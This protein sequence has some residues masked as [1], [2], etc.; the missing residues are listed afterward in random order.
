VKISFKELLGLSAISLVVVDS[1]VLL[2]IPLLRPLLAFAYFAFVP[3]FLILSAMR[4]GDLSS[5]KGSVLSLGVSIGVMLFVGGFANLLYPFGGIS[6]PLS[7]IPIVVTYTVLLAILHL[8]IYKRVSY[9]DEL[10]ENLTTQLRGLKNSIGPFLLFPALFPFLA[11]FGTYLMNG[12]G[13]NWLLLILPFLILCYIVVLVYLRKSIPSVIFPAT[14]FFIST[15][16]LLKLGLTSQYLVGTDAQVEFEAFLRTAAAGYWSLPA[17]STQAAAL[18][19]FTSTLSTSLLPTVMNSLLNV[20][21]IYIYKAFYPLLLAPAAVCVY[22]IATRYLDSTRA[23]LASFLFVFQVYILEGISTN[24]REYPA[25]LFCALAF[26]VLIDDIEGRSRGFSSSLLLCLFAGC[27]IVCH[28]PTAYIFITVLLF[29]WVLSASLRSIYK[30]KT[31]KYSLGL[32]LIILLSAAVFFWYGQIA[33]TTFSSDIGFL[34]NTFAALQDIFVVE[35]RSQAIQAGFG[36]SVNSAAQWIRVA[37]DDAT[38][39]FMGIGTLFVVKNIRRNFDEYYLLLLSGIIVAVMWVVIPWLAIFGIGRLIP[40]LFIFLAPAFFFGVDFVFKSLRVPRL[41]SVTA[42]LLVLVLLVSN[43]YLID[44]LLGA[45][46]SVDISN[47]GVNHDSLFIYPSEA[48]GA[49]WIMNYK[50]SDATI[51]SDGF[52]AVRLEMVPGSL[53]FIDATFFDTHFAGTYHSNDTYVYL[54]QT[55][56]NGFIYLDSW[57]TYGSVTLKRALPLEPI[58]SFSGVFNRTSLIYDDGGSQVYKY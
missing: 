28:Y 27:M 9:Q 15:A 40:I 34:Q 8:I 3:G 7:T 33:G 1:V 32:P 25:L 50:Q 23:F 18:S 39:A 20:D 36:T 4:F 45:P 26:L 53:D 29:T 11:I 30:I 22:I 56:V 54:R 52:G 5:I 51:G 42:I 2:N 58:A 13:D 12:W 38:L 43:T 16:L 47:S 48:A 46:T 49:Q 10:T 19:L 17:Y 57:V 21:P 41:A 6:R 37:A 24:I 44:Q 31:T 55:N 14:V 35:S